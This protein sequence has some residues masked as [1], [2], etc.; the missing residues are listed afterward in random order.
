MPCDDNG[1]NASPASPTATQ[2]RP[3]VE[4][5]HEELA[6]TTRA[7][8]GQ[9]SGRRE[10]RN[11]PRVT[12]V[13]FRR[14]LQK[15]NHDP[16]GGNKSASVMYTAIRP[17]PGSAAEYHQPSST[18][19]TRVRLSMRSF[20]DSAGTIAARPTRRS[21]PTRCA[22]CCLANDAVRPS[23]LQ[24]TWSTVDDA[25]GQPRTPSAIHARRPRTHG[26]RRI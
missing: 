10:E 13:W 15:F 9:A 4:S 26:A 1:S 8:G 6:A 18:A 20:N 17:D 14:S 2:L 5:S 25:P 11:T 24:R 21:E 3:L 12:H 16:G 19:S 23:R 22:P 7:P